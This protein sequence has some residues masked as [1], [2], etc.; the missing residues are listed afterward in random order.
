MKQDE[1]MT[2]EVQNGINACMECHTVCEETF[3]YSLQRGGK[4]VD[5]RLLCTIM[6]CSDMTRMCADMCMRKS[7]MSAEMSAMCARICDMCRDMCM[8][9]PDDQQ[10]ARCA[11]A[12]LKCAEACRMMAGA[13]A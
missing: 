9:M 7:T 4:Y 11:E 5:T 8:R 12:C 2:A 10:M 6:D 1:R 13:R 3:N